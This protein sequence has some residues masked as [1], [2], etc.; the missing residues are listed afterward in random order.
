M[1]P[2]KKPKTPQPPRG[3]QQ[4]RVQAPQVRGHAGG[5]PA[6][7][8][9]M[10]LYAVAGSGVIALIAVIVL[11]TAGG[12]GGTNDKNVAKAMT[13]AGC[14]FKTVKASVPGGRTHRASLT[15][16]FHWNTNPPSNGQHYPAWAVWDFYTGEP[17]NPRRVVHNEEHGGVIL[18]WGQQTPGAT[19]EKL[20]AFYEEQPI[21]TF[22]T[23]F[24][25]F[26]SRIAITAWTGDPTKYGRKGYYGFG[27]VA[28]CLRYD[29]A[30]K[31]A[32]ET[33]RDTYRGHGPEGVPLSAD[34]PGLGP[35]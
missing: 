34:A 28:T 12:G 32:F 15:G 1:P 30:T 19:I 23:P 7:R 26:G 31:K 10:I 24:A 33:F 3:G 29:A 11:V 2:K 14:S 13:A 20:R 9:R 5:D 8:Q 27:H 6:A 35:Q 21:G 18:W 22:G 4:R 17:V 16:D 25:N